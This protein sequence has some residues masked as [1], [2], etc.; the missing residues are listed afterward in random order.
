MK[1]IFLLIAVFVFNNAFCQRKIDATDTLTISGKIKNNIVFTLSQL[2][3]FAVKKIDDMFITNHH[4]EIKGAIKNLKGIP[5]KNILEK[6]EIIIDKPKELNEFYF[7]F[8]SSDG[9]KVVFSWN[10]IF[11]TE[12]GDNVFLITEKDGEKLTT[13]S[14]RIIIVSTD[15]Y[16]S[17]RR[18]IKGLNKIIVQ[19]GN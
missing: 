15:D 2:D 7:L 16:N 1:K 5:L 17:G 14:D 3:T 11:N 4:G 12:I 8:I 10:E 6:V 13:M 19:R 9:Y 18:Y